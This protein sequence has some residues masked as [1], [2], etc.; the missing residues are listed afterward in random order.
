MEGRREGRTIRGKGELEGRSK[1]RKSATKEGKREKVDKNRVNTGR[2]CVNVMEMRRKERTR[3]ERKSKRR[4]K[5]R[6]RKRVDGKRKKGRR[7]S[8]R[9]RKY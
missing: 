1:K 5:K 3:A 9:K 2:E 4:K 8:V 7:S 6:K